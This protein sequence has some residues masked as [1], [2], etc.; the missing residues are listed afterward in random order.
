MQTGIFRARL[1]DPTFSQ[2]E[3]GWC[4]QTRKQLNPVQEDSKTHANDKQ[5]WPHQECTSVHEHSVR[6]G[7]YLNQN[8]KQAQSHHTAAPP[9]HFTLLWIRA[10]ECW[11]ITILVWVWVWQGCQELTQH[12]HPLDPRTQRVSLN[13]SPA[14]KTARGTT[15]LQNSDTTQIHKAL[16]KWRFLKRRKSSKSF[17]PS[18]I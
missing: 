5:W 11:F 1:C 16:M 14:T 4:W 3:G 9:A 8:P 7:F 2:R 10:T 18:V 15:M 17:R 13:I 12:L 6:E